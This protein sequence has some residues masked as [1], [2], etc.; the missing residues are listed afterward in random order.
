MST[1]PATTFDTDVLII[2]SGFGG[3]VSALRLAE[4]GYKVMVLEKGRRWKPEDFPK[5][6]WNVP[7]SFWMPW[8]SFYGTWGLHLLRDVLV[9]HGVGV[10]GGSLVYANTHIQPQD[11]VWDDPHWKGLTD[12]RSEMPQWYAQARR[13]LG[14]TPTP[15]IGPG[16]EALKRAAERRGLGHT[17]HP[18]DVGVH[19]GKAGELTPDPYF[20]GKG[21]A[22]T[23]CTFCGACMTGCREGAKNT[24]DKNYLYLAE[25]AGAKV[26]AE[27]QVELVE[28]LPGGGYR[29]SWKRSTTR[30]APERGSFTAEKVV[31]S[32]GVL[33]TVP[34]L[35]KCKEAGSIPNLPAALGAFSRTNSEALLGL[36]SRTRDDVWQGVAIAAHAQ[37]DDVT[38]ME[39]VRFRKGNDVMLLLGTPLTDG[40]GNVPRAVRWMG[41]VLRHPIQFLLTAKPW[42]KAKKSQV[43]LVMQTRDS[44]MTLERAR[45]WYSPFRRV[46]TSRTPPGVAPIPAYIPIANQIARELAQELDAVPQSSL[47]EVLL[48]VSTTAHILG[49]CSIG[50]SG[51]TGVVDHLARVF[52]H[53][54]LYVLD[55]SIVG[56]NLGVNPS[57]TITALSEHAMSRV[58]PRGETSPA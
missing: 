10:G 15:R 20:G 11:R 21:P 26:L 9:M 19:F 46:L 14:S 12:W 57:L 25:Q 42:D 54:G 49:G 53:E 48:D 3:S 13:M 4:K 50:A 1:S 47:N 5:T 43:L 37:I 55:G 52:G 24:L 58:A 35:L 6:N 56:A 38:S 33:G 30:I 39:I 18:T 34:L 28:K 51:D 2:G 31:F 41:N 27:T 16:D 45:T 23:G 44:H 7:R 22:R 36:T 40:G 29:V 17:F 8:M 32:A